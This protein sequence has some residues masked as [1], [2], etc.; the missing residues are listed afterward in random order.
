MEKEIE[1]I[2]ARGSDLAVALQHN[3]LIDEHGNKRA[4]LDT[5]SLPETVQAL[6]YALP[7]EL[8]P[9]VVYISSICAKLEM[10]SRNG[11]VSHDSY[12]R[13]EL[14]VCAFHLNMHP[15][16]R[17]VHFVPPPQ[18]LISPQG[19][20]MYHPNGHFG[21]MQS[22]GGPLIGF[23]HPAG[24]AVEKIG[25]FLGVD[26]F[27]L[28]LAQTD[29]R[30]PV[31]TDFIQIPEPPDIAGMG[32]QHI[33]PIAWP[34][35]H[36]DMHVILP[37]QNA[38]GLSAG[39]CHAGRYALDRHALAELGEEINLCV[40]DQPVPMGVRMDNKCAPVCTDTAGGN[41]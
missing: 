21:Y 30:I 24:H 7:P 39:Q 23:Q 2:R 38:A 36:H 17:L 33:G 19:G 9:A 5:Q 34:K 1:Y 14:M 11:N 13:Y 27:G 37:Q 22:Q 26:L 41:W 6:I 10:L 12:F 32:A 25:G 35:A 29:R 31:I 20:G 4:D 28:E 15:V 8:I 18:S 3:F 16:M 40:A